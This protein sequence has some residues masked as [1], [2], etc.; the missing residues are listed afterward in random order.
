MRRSIPR[1]KIS[2]TYTSL[3]ISAKTRKS[4]RQYTMKQFYMLLGLLATATSVVSAP[5]P[6]PAGGVSTKADDIFY[7]Q[8]HGWGSCCKVDAADAKHSGATANDVYYPT[9]ANA[10]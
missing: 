9:D 7:A 4:R 8:P 3:L 5:I 2:S 6:E 1:V 10:V